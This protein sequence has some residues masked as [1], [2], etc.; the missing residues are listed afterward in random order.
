MV[1]HQV[2]FVILSDDGGA[3]WVVAYHLCEVLKVKS[4]GVVRGLA[5]DSVGADDVGPSTPAFARDKAQLVV[6][7][8]DL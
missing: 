1:R 5:A 3:I 4:D 2:G 6:R 7:G 8:L